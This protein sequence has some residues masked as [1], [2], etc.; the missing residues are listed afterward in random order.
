MLGAVIPLETVWSFADAAL[1]M[2]S[3]PNLIAIVLLSGQV[4]RMTRDYFA[5]DHVPTKK[6]S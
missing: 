1:G 6:P 3:L 2:M 5:Q 4:A